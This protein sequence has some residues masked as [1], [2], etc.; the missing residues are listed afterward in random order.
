MTNSD[1]ERGG[2]DTAIDTDASVRQ[3]P[4]TCMNCSRSSTPDGKPIGPTVIWVISVRRA[5]CEPC[6]RDAMAE[7]LKTL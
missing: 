1:N 7:M 2:C 6:R 3:P 5:L 4:L